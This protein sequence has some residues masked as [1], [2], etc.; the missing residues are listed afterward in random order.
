[1]AE[2]KKREGS[3]HIAVGDNHKL[4]GTVKSSIHLDGLMVSPTVELDGEVI[5]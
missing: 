2:D 4:G 3:V 1:M 5:V